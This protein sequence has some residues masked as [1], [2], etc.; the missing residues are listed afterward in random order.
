MD[1]L[2]SAVALIL[3]HALW[4]AAI[5]WQAAVRA[6]VQLITEKVVNSVWQTGINSWWMNGRLSQQGERTN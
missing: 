6:H 2:S 1:A 3:F 4:V 5:F